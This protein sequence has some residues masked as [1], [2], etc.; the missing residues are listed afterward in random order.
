MRKDRFK[1]SRRT[2][3]MA[4]SCAPGVSNIAIRQRV[5]SP[6]TELIALGA[7][8]DC[9]AQTWDHI[10]RQ[11]N[12]TYETFIVG[13]IEAINPIEA[14]IVASRAKTIEGLL[15]KA[16]AANWS[17]EG[18]IYPEEE[19]STDERMAWSIV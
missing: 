14:A 18:H 5:N 3:L 11:S 4:L 19:I 9:L 13:L 17:R 10:E 7:Q 16:R 1:V 8:F 15:V 12:H 6:D 2:L